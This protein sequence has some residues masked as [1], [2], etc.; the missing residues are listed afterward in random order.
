MDELIDLKLSAEATALERIL[1][2]LEA[3]VGEDPDS[4]IGLALELFKQWDGVFDQDARGAL[5][6]EEF[7]APFTAK[8]GVFPYA[9]QHNYAVAW[10]IDDPLNTPYGIKDPESAIDMLRGAIE[11]T[12]EKYGAIDRAYGDVSRF[13]IG[14]QDLP[15]LGGFGNLGALNV[16]TWAD[17][18]GDNIR[19]P[20]HGETWI[21][22]VEFSDP[23]KAF[24]LMTYGNSRQPGTNHNDDQVEMLARGEF[25]EL[26]LLRDQVEANTEHRTVLMYQN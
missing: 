3:A 26:W 12:K 20:A 18:D 22:I 1:P 15:G 10:S 6:F 14:E 17:F 5:L 11:R 2:D 7:M 16:I 21:S 9:S 19:T 25:R 23:I 13:V 4:E 24:G 8:P